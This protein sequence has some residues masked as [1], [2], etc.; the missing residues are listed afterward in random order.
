MLD[1]T[2]FRIGRVLPLAVVLALG[3]AGA[4][5]QEAP[6]QEVPAPAA[7]QP[8]APAG[9]AAAPAQ[10]ILDQAVLDLLKT[11]TAQIAAAKGLEIGI[12]DLRDV[13]S[14]QGQTLIFVN[15]ADIVV[16]RPDKLRLKGSI[17]GA[18]TTV[19]YDGET[20]SIYD[21]EQNVVAKAEIAGTLDDMIAVAAEKYGVHFAFA[22]FLFSDPYAVL[23][24]GLTHAYEAPTTE[25]DATDTRH[26][27]FAAPG[28][29][30]QLWVDPETSLP[31]MFAVTYTDRPGRPRFLVD[32]L[33]WDLDPEI[34]P[35]DFELAL[36]A[37]ASVIEF[38][39][40]D[41]Q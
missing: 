22:D 32:F 38:L 37:D 2:R 14:D 20:L 8:S 39:P 13:P 1:I 21:S 33:S 11:T 34:E 15:E 24:K 29:E 35:G 16:Q 9:E 12:R 4:A 30:W 10:P 28:I 40:N 18:D 19:V 25:L 27:V 3:G 23:S 5:A 7:S 36:P 31:R 17:G 41:A 6:A 26:L